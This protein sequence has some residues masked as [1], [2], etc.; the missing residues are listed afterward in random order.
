MGSFNQMGFISNLPIMAGDDA[1]MIFMIRSNHRGDSI[2]GVVSCDDI[3]TPVLLPIFGKYDDYGNIDNIERDFA[4]KWIEELFGL[5]IDSI[6]QR[7]Q[8]DRNKT[9]SPKEND[10]LEKLTF[11]L[12]HRSFYDYLSNEFLPEN[13]DPI[14]EFVRGQYEPRFLI[15]GRRFLE[16]FQLFRKELL[17]DDEDLDKVISK[18]DIDCLMK[19]I[20]F[21]RGVGRLNSKYFPSNYGNQDQDLEL[22]F[23]V[24][25]LS[26]RLIV[27]KIKSYDDGKE[28]ISRIK[29]EIRDE[30]IDEIFE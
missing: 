24:L 23:K 16:D 20:G 15:K 26:R 7:A 1:V 12:E 19:T 9:Q 6:T 29:K 5:D 25:T 18:L 13:Q 14:K 27:E 8:D 21:H 2:E 4:C 10:L 17:K 28:V 11:G 22:Y 30:K 3:F